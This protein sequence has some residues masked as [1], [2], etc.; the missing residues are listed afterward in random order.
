MVRRINNE[1]AGHLDKQMKCL[2]HGKK[3][4]KSAKEESASEAEEFT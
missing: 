4:K 1:T 3:K 2:G